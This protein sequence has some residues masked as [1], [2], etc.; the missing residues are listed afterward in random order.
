MLVAAVATPAAGAE[1][2]VGLV[3]FDHLLSTARGMLGGR[4]EGGVIDHTRQIEA[5][6]RELSSIKGEF[7]RERGRLSAEARERY[8]R[9]IVR[10]TEEIQR[11]HGETVREA[12]LKVRPRSLD[13]IRPEVEQ[14]IQRYGRDHRFARILNR[15]DRRVLYRAE[16]P[17]ETGNAEEIDITRNLLELLP[18][19]LSSGRIGGRAGQ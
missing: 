2:R 8:E 12:L 18:V 17:E 15:G 1:P 4:L 9:D 7:A 11:L 3:D 13:A 6:E 5:L 19:E 10:R 14:M 16:G